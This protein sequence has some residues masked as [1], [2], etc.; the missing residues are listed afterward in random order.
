MI[1]KS[2]RLFLLYSKYSLK[3]IFQ[4][5]FGVILLT[6]GKAIR[7]LF[8]LGLIYIVFS[9]TRVVEGYSLNQ[10]IIFFL[11]FNIIDTVSQLLF[12]EVYRFRPQVVSGSF[13]LILLKPHHPFLRILVGG[14]DFLD[15]I[16]LIPYILL[17]IYFVLQLPISNFNLPS[18]IL[19][20]L[21]MINSLFIAA[22]FHIAVLALA[23]L[24][25][26]VD[27]T[28]MIYRDLTNLGRFPIDIYR[29]PIRGIFTFIIPVAVMMTFPVKALFNLLSLPTILLSFILS[30]I[31]LF[32]SYN[33][34]NAALKKYQSWGG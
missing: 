11:T 16:M 18:S 31:A 30:V 7:F 9:K 28:I 3:T 32:G 23:I 12:R 20:L 15:L 34:W 14:V 1:K 25:T 24:T 33:L 2:L 21:L 13:D 29:E 8:L 10:M 17:T 19:Y 5:R 22:A 27:H 6:L 4:S 26:D